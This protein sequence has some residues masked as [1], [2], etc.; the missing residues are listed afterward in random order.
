M[1]EA[2][3]GAIEAGGTKF[4]L[5]VGEEPAHPREIER[6][7]TAADPEETL[8][9]IVD[10][11]R[12]FGPL[13]AIGVASFG[14]IDFE[15]GAI[16]R[17]PKAGWGGFPLVDAI[18]KPL[19]TRVL[20]DTDVNGAALG[21]ARFG[22]GIGLDSFIY[23]T[24]GTGIGGGAVVGGR[25]IHGLLHPEMGHL[26]VRRHPEDLEG[27]MGVCPFHRDCLEGMASGS[28]MRARWGAGAETLPDSHPAWQLEAYYLAQA[29][30]SMVCLLS[31]RRIVIGGGVAA[32]ST[33]FPRIHRELATI[34]AGYLPLP[35]VVAPELDYPA[36]TGALV[37]AREAV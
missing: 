33:L 9:Q 13:A 22:A 15:R 36:L 32:R 20:L 16:G 11:F 31:P 24:V 34:A 21:E 29:C 8:A 17:T 18:A 2:L 37:M 4:L 26:P 14:P 35:A 10:Y 1:P 30:F 6:V 3:Y 12:Q 5:A 28:S 23:L 27:F 25:T 7:A 19:N